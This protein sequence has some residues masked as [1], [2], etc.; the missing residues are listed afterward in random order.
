MA[1]DAKK[2]KI[3]KNKPKERG[4]CHFSASFQQVKYSHPA[5]KD[6]DIVDYF[7]AVFDTTVLEKLL[8]E[9]LVRRSNKVDAVRVSSLNDGTLWIDAFC[10]KPRSKSKYKTDKSY[11]LGIF[12]LKLSFIAK[13]N[14]IFVFIEDILYL[15][16]VANGVFAKFRQA[17]DRFFQNKAT[18][19]SNAMQFNLELLA[20][21]ELADANS[22]KF[23]GGNF[24][25][26][27]DSI[28]FS[29]EN[30]INT[31]IPSEILEFEELGQETREHDRLIIAGENKAY[32][33]AMSQLQ[34]SSR[35]LQKRLF[36]CE[37]ENNNY[38]DLVANNQ[39]LT[40]LSY[41]TLRAYANQD[42]IA[43]LSF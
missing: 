1:L 7:E 4:E 35:S 3:R 8:R 32:L 25:F 20:L 34:H 5:T 42:K 6:S 16:F 43:Y 33:K 29:S 10:R 28:S 15:G 19:E 18:G 30:P 14:T 24:K 22:K 11:P 31:H 2:I 38:S 26:S 41:E 9:Q 39:S 27:S 36:L 21:D 13:N 23:M 40:E 17:L 37:I 12:S